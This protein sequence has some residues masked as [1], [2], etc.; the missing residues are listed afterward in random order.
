MVNLGDNSKTTSRCIHAEDY[1]MMSDKEFA[2]LELSAVICPE[3]F[4]WP[5]PEH[6]HWQKLHEAASEARERVRQARMQMD[7]FDRNIDLPRDDKYHQRSK[8]ADEA[9]ADFEA[10]KTLTRAREAVNRII[11]QWKRDEQHVTT[12]IAEA[13][14][15]AMNE[16]SGGGKRPSIR[17]LSVLA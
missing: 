14:L 1:K 8:I 3:Q 13:A 7:E 17:S 6:A 10:S 9:I 15:K 2:E 11:Q 12:E 16:V 5:K 4:R